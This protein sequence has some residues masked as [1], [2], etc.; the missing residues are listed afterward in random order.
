MTRL[1]TGVPTSAIPGPLLSRATDIPLFSG[2]PR[3]DLA[4]VLSQAE[5][6]SLPG[7]W[8]LFRE[9]DPA[10][11]V[12]IVLAGRLG[13]S[14][15]RPDGGRA[16]IGEV[17]AGETVG[18][19]AMLSGM[20]RS[21]TIVAL[22][23]TELLRLPRHAFEALL[24]RRPEAMRHIGRVLVDRLNRAAHPAAATG[25]PGTIALVPLTPDP[26]TASLARDLARELTKSGRRCALVGP[27][28]ADRPADWFHRLEADHDHV[29]YQAD[30]ADSPWSRQCLRQADRIL[31][32]ASASGDPPRR[33]LT[34]RACDL[35]LLHGPDATR[36]HGAAPWLAS[37]PA[38]LHSH[39]RAG[40]QADIGRLARLLTGRAVGLVLSGG[41]ARGFAHIGVV[42]A[43]R[44][45]GLP[46]DIA[47]GVSMGAITAAGVAMEWSDEEFR[48]RMK[49]CF[50]ET[51]PLGDF[52]VPL[53]SL[54]SGRRVTRRLRRHFGEA[55]IEN[56]WR[57][58]FAVSAN[59]TTGRQ[60][61]HRRGPV[62]RALRA[63]IAIPGLLPPVIE[64]GE[65]LVDGGTLNNFPVD[66]LAAMGRGPVIGSDVGRIRCVG[67][68]GDDRASGVLAGLLRKWRGGAPGI[69]D[70]LMRAGTVS[71]DA[72]AE[73]LRGAVDLLFEPPV[74]SFDLR[75][76]KSF[77]RIVEAGY[78]HAAGILART[79]PEIT[80][81]VT[82]A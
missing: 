46:I 47:G 65:V 49:R 36:P 70:L 56:L 39:V 41:G 38:E 79:G 52:T 82:I 77:D 30:N 63:S 58:F 54:V 76:W 27:D 71:S 64:D 73:E 7:G 81:T 4:R 29:V 66:A 80:R 32:A 12:H 2:L 6:F 33:T 31:F 15:G 51:N 48:D 69:V 18:E 45:A 8:T 60:H 62:W 67:D 44:E 5:W 10:Q 17:G 53:V 74:G 22:R 23:D 57:P 40:N 37:I 26:R 59:L 61:P 35:V 55:E 3:R 20:S 13:V 34:T 72:R 16:P 50:V 24:D 42:R 21:A 78:R 9:G 68:C 1:R 14:V 43:L 11:A 19:M 25:T 28:H 75:D